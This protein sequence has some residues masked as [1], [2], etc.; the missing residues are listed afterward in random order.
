MSSSSVSG[1]TFDSAKYSVITSIKAWLSAA[2]RLRRRAISSEEDMAQDQR[3][4]ERSG[5]ET[6]G[7]R[8][9]FAAACMVYVRFLMP[10]TIIIVFPRFCSPCTQV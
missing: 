7:Y 5:Y 2:P 8:E 6:S 3:S 9:T 4:E 1:S 10:Y